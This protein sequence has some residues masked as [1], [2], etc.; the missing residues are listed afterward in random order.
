MSN[1]GLR[2]LKDIE[3]V[4]EQDKG[5]SEA[6]RYQRIKEAKEVTK[7]P[8]PSFAQEEE[9]EEKEEDEVIRE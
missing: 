1:D 4:N 6:S 8:V 5:E 3:V 2:P 9:E 7:K